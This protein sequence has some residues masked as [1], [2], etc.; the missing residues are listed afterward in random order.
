MSHGGARPGAGR[1]RG[2]GKYG[3]MT[4]SV[5]IP[6]SRIKDVM[7][8]IKGEN[9]LK[10][11]FY[12][13]S[14][15]AGFPSPADDYIETMLDLN[16]YL[17]KHPAATFFVKASGDSMI[18]AGIHSGDILVVDRSLEAT[19][20]RIVIAAVNG[21]LTVKRL[22]RQQGRVKLVAENP[23]FPPLDITD[24]HDMVIWGVVTNVIHAVL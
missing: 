12:S 5:R 6:E 18:H 22:F 11:P 2:Q 9:S 7:K 4:K 13:S 17:I 10:I 1:P 8:Y 23:E 16:E 24:A 14:V 19:H 15:R 3:E 21:E 20:G